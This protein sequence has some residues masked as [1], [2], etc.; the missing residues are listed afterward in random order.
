MT[1]IDLSAIRAREA[2]APKPPWRV[3]GHEIL[4]DDHQ[5]FVQSVSSSWIADVDPVA[6]EEVDFI[7]H[8]RQDVPDLLAEVARLTEERDRLA[9]VVAALTPT[10][11]QRKDLG[12]FVEDVRSP[13]VWGGVERYRKIARR[14]ASAHLRMMEVLAEAD[15]TREHPV[16]A[17]SEQGR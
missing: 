8:A 6:T 1:A 3:E 15:P 16:G 11:K 4:H 12:K 7:I 9:V 2:A 13:D 14:F 17:E 5:P 10:T